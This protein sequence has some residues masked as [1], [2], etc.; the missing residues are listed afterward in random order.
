MTFVP[1]F[2]SLLGP[3]S[4]QIPTVIRNRRRARRSVLI[5]LTA[6]ATGHL[7]L[8]VAVETNRP[9]WRDPDYGHRLPLV[10]A[11]PKNRPLVV[12]LGSSRTQMGVCPSAMGLPDATVINFGM[13]GAGPFHHR[14]SLGRL[15]AAGVHPDYLLVEVMPVAMTQESGAEAAFLPQ[16]AR[17]SAADV[18]RLAPYC[19]DASGLWKA[20]AVDRINSW[21]SLRLLLMSHTLP[22]FL[23]WQARQ[24]FRWRDMDRTGWLPY[25]FEHLTDTDRRQGLARTKAELGR[26]LETFHIAAGPD[27]VL[28]DL[29]AEAKRTGIRI[30]LYRMP[31]SPL[32]RTW[33]PP[34]AHMVISEYLATLSRE[35]G[36]PA[37]DAADWLGEDS[38]SDGHHM[39]RIGAKVFSERFGRECLGPWMGESHSER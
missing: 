34:T 24:D 27:R 10:T 29:I 26:A 37:F 16:A 33:Y 14:M 2:R 11:V 8:A 12:A 32:Y 18:A 35:Y 23:P 31:E 13:A 21:Y 36:I 28:R 7:G 9:Q 25:P 5:G 4:V 1:Q 22:G 20:W 3:G 19:R 30:A 38:F 15:E 6:V 39:L 17:L